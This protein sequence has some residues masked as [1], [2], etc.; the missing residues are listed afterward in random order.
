MA[1]GS[2]E[3]GDGERSMWERARSDEHAEAVDAKVFMHALDVLMGSPTL[4]M[5]TIE[6]IVQER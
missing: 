4:H 2:S 1:D 6:R 5:V 3:R